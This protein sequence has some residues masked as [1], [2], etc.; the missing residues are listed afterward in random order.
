M[1]VCEWFSALA[2][3]A[4]KTQKNMLGQFLANFSVVAARSSLPSQLV[5]QAEHLKDVALPIFATHEV[6]LCGHSLK[7]IETA[8]QRMELAHLAELPSRQ[9]SLIADGQPIIL[10]IVVTEAAKQ[11]SP[12]SNA[13]D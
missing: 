5:G 13:S 4:N 3:D 10:E 11:K 1:P 12:T 9:Q 7:R 2:R 8:M 6:M